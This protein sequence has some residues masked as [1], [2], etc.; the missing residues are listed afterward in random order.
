QLES[1]I[2]DYYDQLVSTIAKERRLDQSE[3]KKLIDEG[4]FTAA[5]AKEAGLIDRVAYADDFRNQLADEHKAE[6]VTVL[7]D[8]GKQKVDDDFSGIGGLVK[9]MELFSGTPSKSR[10]S[11]TKKVAVV[12]V[13]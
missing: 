12:Y 5:Q 1:V 10:S 6:D 9:L 4:L 8:Y 13:V 3:V 2:D 7:E 11:S